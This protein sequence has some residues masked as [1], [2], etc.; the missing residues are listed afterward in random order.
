MARQLRFFL[1]FPLIAGALVGFLYLYY[2]KRT[3]IAGKW[4]K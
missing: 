1:I 4:K 3:E 2:L